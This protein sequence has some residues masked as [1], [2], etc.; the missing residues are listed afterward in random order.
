M[1]IENGRGIE[2]Q[3]GID[4]IFLLGFCLYE[5]ETNGKFGKN[6][7]PAFISDDMLILGYDI[8]SEIY[9]VRAIDTIGREFSK[10]ASSFSN[11]L[12]G[13]RYI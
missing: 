1:I 4:N 2:W 12:E 5:L 13:L 7:K 11:S 8:G 6:E 3:I 9:Y 10:S